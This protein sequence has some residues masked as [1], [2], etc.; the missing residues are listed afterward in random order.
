MRTDQSIAIFV[1]DCE[2][3]GWHKR[4]DLKSDW[5]FSVLVST[6]RRLQSY[7]D[8][9]TTKMNCKLAKFGNW[10]GLDQFERKAESVMVLY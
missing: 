7:L 9:N 1:L 8:A 2:H 3:F 4:L 10:V 5:R 6:A